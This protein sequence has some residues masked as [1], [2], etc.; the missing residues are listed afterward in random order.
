MATIDI[1][2]LQKEKA[3]QIELKEEIFGVP[4][5]S[6]ILHQ[7][8]VS[9]LN[10]RRTGT[11]STKGRSEVKSSGSKLWRQKGTG[12]ARV[13]DAAS[14]TRRGGGVVFGPKPRKY[15]TKVPKKV[16]RAA[17]KMALSDK[18]L[19][20]R[21]VVLSDFDLPEIKTKGFVEVMKRFDVSKVLIVTETKN[22]N[23]E[24]SARNVP[25][26]KVLRH[27]GLNVYDILNHE[28]LFLLEPTVRRIE[29]ALV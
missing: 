22:E 2:N 7:V 23:L 24:K 11:A 10:A 1:Y 25:R 9:Q 12:R 16:K 26:V 27:E 4:V 13:G 6:H 20:D 8:V 29:E 17:L 28:H 21:L 3:G 19:N 15:V 18:A 14:P 5:K